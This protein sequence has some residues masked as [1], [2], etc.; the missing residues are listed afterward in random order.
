[1]LGNGSY[2]LGNGLH[3]IGNGPYVLGNGLHLSGIMSHSRSCRILHYVKF[4]IM[5]HSG[6]CRSALCRI[7]GYV[8]GHNV[9]FSIMSHSD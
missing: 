1:M 9:T 4:R 7:R 8:A 3:G 6:L 5:L 2:V